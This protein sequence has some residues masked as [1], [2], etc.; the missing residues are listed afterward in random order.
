L[1]EGDRYSKTQPINWSSDT[2][3]NYTVPTTVTYTTEG[4]VII[5]LEIPEA[6]EQG[7]EL[8]RHF[9]LKALRPEGSRDAL[10]SFSGKTQAPAR[11]LL[12]DF[13]ECLRTRIQDVLCKEHNWQPVKWIKRD[14]DFILSFPSMVGSE[15][16]QI[17]FETASEIFNGGHGATHQV[18]NVTVSEA[19]AAGVCAVKSLRDRVKV[20]ISF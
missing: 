6:K 11:T 20:S 5:G 19:E 16:A 4:Q 15:G 7:L 3:L 1:P 13:L 9:K 14:V 12:R 18:L 10:Y 8:F 17:M 2:G